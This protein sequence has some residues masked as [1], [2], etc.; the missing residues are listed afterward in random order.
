M[1]FISKHQEAIMLAL[2]IAIIGS[3]SFNYVFDSLADYC[4]TYEHKFQLAFDSAKQASQKNQE[5]ATLPP[6]ASSVRIEDGPNGTKN[7]FVEGSIPLTFDINAQGTVEVFD[8]S[9]YLRHI[10]IWGILKNAF[11]LL[12]DISR[13]IF[14][15]TMCLSIL[16]PS[17]GRKPALRLGWTGFSLTLL[18]PLSSDVVL[19]LVF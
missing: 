8:P 15:T 19:S 6:S 2:M 4:A 13:V 5:S 16:T 1:T 11:K 14:V 7:M 12:R 17:R 18:S 10:L 3:V 9:A